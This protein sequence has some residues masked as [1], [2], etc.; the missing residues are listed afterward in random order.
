MGEAPVAKFQAHRRQIN[1]NRF[2]LPEQV[3][4]EGSSVQMLRCMV[5]RPEK[6][7]ELPLALA[8]LRVRLAGLREERS[9][10]NIITVLR[11]AL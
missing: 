5:K 3:S 1:K 4:V 7:L 10:L 2:A 8:A 6:H 11:D 9:L